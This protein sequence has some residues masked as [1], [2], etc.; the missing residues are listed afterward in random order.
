MSLP[1]LD[2]TMFTLAGTGMIKIKTVLLIAFPI[3]VGPAALLLA[4]SMEGTA[5]ERM[6]AS[7]LAGIISTLAIVFTAT[8]GTKVTQVLN[9]DVL[10]IFGAAMVM[11]ISLMMFGL[12]IPEKVPLFLMLGGMVLSFVWR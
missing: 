5:K 8:I 2:G 3:I 7:L 10:R 6:L 11:L 12:K 9:F 1:A 4:A